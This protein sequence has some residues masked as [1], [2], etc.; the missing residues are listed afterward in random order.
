MHAHCKLMSIEWM[1]DDDNALMIV[2]MAKM[3]KE[4]FNIFWLLYIFS[5]NSHCVWGFDFL[6]SFAYARRIS[7]AIASCMTNRWQIDDVGQ[8][9]LHNR[10]CFDRVFGLISILWRSAATSESV[11][12]SRRW[13]CWILPRDDTRELKLHFC[14]IL[15][16]SLTIS[17]ND[18]KLLLYGI[19]HDTFDY[20]KVYLR[21]QFTASQ[22][23][24]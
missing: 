1:S 15:C 17:F 7:M 22:S 8:S 2:T 9:V 20:S 13:S 5:I 24:K 16:I 14:A 11:N 21:S 12:R 10:V 6:T 23:P 3:F 4:N 18:Y 19:S